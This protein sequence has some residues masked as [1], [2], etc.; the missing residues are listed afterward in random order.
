MSREGDLILGRK[1]GSGDVQY[2]EGPEEVGLNLPKYRV[3]GNGRQDVKDVLQDGG[4]GGA[5]IRI[6]DVG[7]DPAHHQDAGGNLPL[8]GPTDGGEKMQRNMDKTYPYPPLVEAMAEADWR[9]WRP[10]S[11]SVRT[12]SH[13]PLRPI[14]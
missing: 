12:K 5:P 8:G 9:R 11:P 1:V 6:R 2:A 13:S 3:R 7:H 10:M 4:S 14:Q